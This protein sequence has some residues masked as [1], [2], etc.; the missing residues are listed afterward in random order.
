MPSGAEHLT[1]WLS[2]L[3]NVFQTQVGFTGQPV[4]PGGPA[5][6]GSDDY[7][8]T[9]YGAPTFGLGALGW[10]YGNITWHTDRDTYDKV[11]F[12]DLKANATLTAML[13]Y[14]ASED[15]GHVTPINPD[16]AR[17]A[18]QVVL[19][20]IAKVGGVSNLGAGRGNRGGRGGFGGPRLWPECEKVPRTTNPRLGG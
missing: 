13:V 18:T 1:Q 7:S 12:D 4:A 10:D 15:P 9:C 8:F 6:G 3:P 2:K 19:D 16:S 5:G 17:A 14:L 11:V 20:S